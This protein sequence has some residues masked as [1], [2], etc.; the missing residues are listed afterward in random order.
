MD[1]DSVYDRRGTG[2]VK[3]NHLPEGTIPMWIADMDFKSPPSVIRALEQAAQHGIYGYGDTDEEYDALVTGW[4][5][6][7]NGWDIPSEALLKV[8]GVMFGVT[9]AL[10]AMTEPGDAVLICQPVYYPFERIIPGNR[11]RL[12]ISPLILKDGRYAV[13]FEDFEAKIRQNQ[14]KAFLLCSPHNPVEHPKMF[15]RPI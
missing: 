9:A 10:Q 4:Y 3:Y 5:R 15:E 6:R 12:V 7:R 14:V 8:P 2:A 11:R 1:F 13:D